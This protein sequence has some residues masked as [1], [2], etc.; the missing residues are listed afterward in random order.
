MPARENQL[1][2]CDDNVNISSIFL[3]LSTETVVIGWKNQ[4]FPGVGGPYL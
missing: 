3:Q 2:T 4:V 1:V